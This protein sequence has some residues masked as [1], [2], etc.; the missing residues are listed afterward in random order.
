MEASI[1]GYTFYR[2]VDVNVDAKDDLARKAARDAQDRADDAYSLANSKPGRSD[3]FS[4]NYND[5]T[6]KPTDVSFQPSKSNIYNAV[7]EIFHPATQRAVTAD[8]DNNEIDIDSSKVTGSLTFI[9]LGGIGI[10]KGTVAS[11]G[12][13]NFRDH[14]TFD[15]ALPAGN[16]GF[17]NNI[18]IDSAHVRQ[19]LNIPFSPPTNNTW[20]LRIRSNRV[21]DSKYEGL[22]MLPWYLWSAPSALR[23]YHLIIDRTGNYVD[24]NIQRRNIVGDDVIQIETNIGQ[25]PNAVDIHIDLVVIN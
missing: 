16:Y 14:F 17:R 3:V 2:T 1:Q 6:N 7:K 15:D 20:G 21:G 11:S 10:A 13:L 4:G 19:G 23:V 12:F 9:R 18:L 5:L 22:L 24:I 8:D 25:V